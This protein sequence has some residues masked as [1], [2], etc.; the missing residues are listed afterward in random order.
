MNSRG[1]SRPSPNI[2]NINV[3]TTSMSE[4]EKTSRLGVGVWCTCV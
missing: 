1:T 3:S 2:A 4:L